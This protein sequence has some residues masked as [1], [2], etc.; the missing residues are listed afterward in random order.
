MTRRSKPQQGAIR[1][2]RLSRV[3][4]V[5]IAEAA[6][7]FGVPKGTVARLRKELPI[8]TT[9]SLGDLLLAALTTE[10][11]VSSGKLDDLAGLA[12]WIDYLN[13]DGCDADD[14]RRML[15]ELAEGGHLDITDGKWKLLRPWP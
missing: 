8:E 13:H 3:R 14:I 11:K 9:L 12:G 1:A 5:T 2:A 7:R 6:A 10:G 15:A 4:G